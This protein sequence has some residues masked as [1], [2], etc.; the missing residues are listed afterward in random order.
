MKQEI[1]T[2]SQNANAV[3]NTSQS[4]FQGKNMVSSNS[5][6]SLV[7]RRL[8]NEMEGVSQLDVADFLGVSETLINDAIQGIQTLPSEKEEAI[9]LINALWDISKIS[10]EKISQEN[11]KKFVK[12]SVYK[13]TKHY[14]II[15]LIKEISVL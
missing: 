3:K 1:H 9:L 13:S 4:K 7:L 15:G 14:A 2:S 5:I 11:L 6:S 10:R 8:L 12:N